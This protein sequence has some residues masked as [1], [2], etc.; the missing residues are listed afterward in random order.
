MDPQEIIRTAV[1]AANIKEGISARIACLISNTNTR[2]SILI[3]R[4]S[5]WA[6]GAVMPMPTSPP[7]SMVMST[8]L[9]VPR[10]KFCADCTTNSIAPPSRM[11]R[12]P[13]VALFISVIL[14]RELSSETKTFLLRSS[15]K[16][17]SVVISCASRR[18]HRQSIC[19]RH[20]TCWLYRSS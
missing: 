16:I 6:V 14:G 18:V 2:G 15:N 13:T 17:G 19:I 8:A 12:K 3:I 7:F 5:S 9:L 4:T 1:A 11:S 20:C 10:L